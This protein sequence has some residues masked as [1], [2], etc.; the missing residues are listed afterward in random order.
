M[1]L[2]LDTHAFLWVLTDDRRLSRSAKRAIASGS[3]DV[4][5][6][7]ITAWEIGIKSASGRLP[8]P[9]VPEDWIPVE[10]ERARLTELPFTM[11]HG[12]SV[13]RLPP[14]HRDPFDRALVAQAIAESL[15][16]VTADKALGA[17]GVSIL[18]AS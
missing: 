5:V 12:A 7:A 16:F 2:L 13:R 8:A 4:F 18:A 17:Y 15:T 3:N 1:R 6:S 10:M 14:Y 11:R 9:P